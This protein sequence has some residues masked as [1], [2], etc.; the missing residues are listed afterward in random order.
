MFS[1][2]RRKLLPHQEESLLKMTELEETKCIDH[3]INTSIGV[4]CDDP[5]SGKTSVCIALIHQKKNEIDSVTLLPY[6]IITN[7]YNHGMIIE[8]DKLNLK[9]I[10]GTLVITNLTVFYH[11]QQE[12]ENMTNLKTCV[13]NNKTRLNIHE[14]C[15]SDIILCIPSL[16]NLLMDLTTEYLWN[17]FIYDEPTSYKIRNMKQINSNFTWIVT[18][19]PKIFFQR[20]AS[21][22]FNG[23]IQYSFFEKLFIHSP[24]SDKET[25]SQNIIIQHYKCYN[26]K[27]FMIKDM[28]NRDLYEKLENNQIDY[29]MD[30][31]DVYATKYPLEHIQKIFDQKIYNCGNKILESTTEEEKQKLSK[32]IQQLTHQKEEW[33]INFYDYL[34]NQCNVC[35]SSLNKPI[36]VN[37]CNQFFCGKCILEWLRKK[38]TC[39]TCRAILTNDLLT[40][41][42]SKDD[43]HE[44]KLFD[45]TIK[46]TNYEYIMEIIRKNEKTTIY[47]DHDVHNFF[48]HLELNKI[49][50]SHLKGSADSRKKKLSRFTTLNNVLIITSVN[51]CIGLSLPLVRH[52]VFQ[53]KICKTI[54]ETIINI[55]H[56]MGRTNPLNI[57]F[58]N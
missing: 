4:Y 8:E 46:K 35:F 54:S 12:I 11:W 45:Y 51:S 58:L 26:P 6:K 40:F 18:G 9:S 57:Y 53:H 34:E 29:I 56:R 28:F 39:P 7:I 17:R 15:I 33:I 3:H 32:T 16:Y 5:G 49:E 48:L 50:Y 24:N 31:I 1:P 25:D 13:I 38:R 37:C 43:P 52:L 22:Y 27:E 10:K 44:D 36:I 2:L 41:I 20:L 14:I 55:H 21:S 19:R 23:T 30:K 47:I 42:R